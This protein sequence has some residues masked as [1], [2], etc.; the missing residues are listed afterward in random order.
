MIQKTKGIKPYDDYYCYPPP[1]SIEPHC[2]KVA[3]FNKENSS[4][5]IR[6]AKGKIGLIPDERHDSYKTG[7]YDNRTN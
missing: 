1:L 6:A 7:I 3:K 4:K 2:K 5:L